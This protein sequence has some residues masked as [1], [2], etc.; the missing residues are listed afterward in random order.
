[1]LTTTNKHV[2][3]VSTSLTRDLPVLVG[4]DH[5]LGGL[6]LGVCLGAFVGVA[7]VVSR[8]NGVGD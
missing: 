5:D 8:G 4:I 3:C 6:A 7:A 1:M 2:L